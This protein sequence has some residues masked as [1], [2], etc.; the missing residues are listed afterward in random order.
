MLPATYGFYRGTPNMKTITNIVFTREKPKQYDEK[1]YA[2]RAQTSEIMGYRHDTTVY[3][4]LESIFMPTLTPA[5][6]LRVSTLQNCRFGIICNQL[7][8]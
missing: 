1:W 3:I 6:C 2:N 5:I 7:K 8:D 4:L